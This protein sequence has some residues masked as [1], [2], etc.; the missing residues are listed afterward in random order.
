MSVSLCSSTGN[1]H[2]QQ[3]TTELQMELPRTPIA[4]ASSQKHSTPDPVIILEL[5]RP[6]VVLSDHMVRRIATGDSHLK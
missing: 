5:N 2:Y 6:R 3:H 4:T 1:L